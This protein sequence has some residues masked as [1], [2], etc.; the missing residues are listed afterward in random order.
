M[1]KLFSN[2]CF[3]L[4]VISFLAL[5][6]GG[7]LLIS[8][9]IAGLTPASWSGQITHIGAILAD[10]GLVGLPLFGWLCSRGEKKAPRSLDIDHLLKK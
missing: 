10:V 5:V 4:T 2:I 6:G 8:G 7:I 9:V 1:N 3:V